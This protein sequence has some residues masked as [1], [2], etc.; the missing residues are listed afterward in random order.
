LSKN[1]LIGIV[2]GVALITSIVISYYVVN[3]IIIH[4][5]VSIAGFDEFGIKEIYPTKQGGEEWY[6][7]MLDPKNDPRTANTPKMTQNADGSWKVAFSNGSNNNNNQQQ[8]QIIPIQS[9]GICCQNEVRYSILTTSGYDDNKIILDQNELDSRGYMQSPNDWKNVEITGYA[10]LISTTGSS[11]A[12]KNGGWTWEARGAR[13]FGSIPPDV[14]YGASYNA[15][16]LWHTGDVRWEK[17]Q[18]H[19]HI[20]STDYHH[21]SAISLGRFIGFKAIMYNTQL[22]GK[23]VV[24]LEIWLDPND[25]NRWHKAYQFTDTGGWGDAGQE[26]GGSPDQI[27]TWGGPIVIFRWDEATNV[28]IKD[29]SVREIQPT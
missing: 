12:V 10:K 17:E 27:I 6:M 13:H 25:D 15:H 14:C 16:I 22:N 8:Q 29:F 24:K 19:D 20:V 21:T 5:P 28:D 7:N 1:L 26:C 9:S 3:N 18:W 2:I 4:R 11:F 23:T